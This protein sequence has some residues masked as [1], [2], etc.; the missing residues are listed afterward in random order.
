MIWT[1]ISDLANSTF[2]HLRL[3]I[4]IIFIFLHLPLGY[5]FI[6]SSFLELINA[7]NWWIQE[8]KSMYLS[9]LTTSKAIYQ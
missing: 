7:F 3:I 8:S 2:F 5:Y 9:D 1:I 6:E 4:I